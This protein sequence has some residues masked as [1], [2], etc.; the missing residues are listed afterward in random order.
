MKQMNDGQKN[1]RRDKTN[2]G[3]S[4]KQLFWTALMLLLQPAKEWGAIETLTVVYFDPSVFLVVVFFWLGVCLSTC[5]KK[6]QNSPVWEATVNTS[7]S[8]A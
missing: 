3:G 1:E 5:L 2:V 4:W 7:T 6:F 8:V